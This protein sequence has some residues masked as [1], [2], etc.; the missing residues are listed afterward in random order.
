MVESNLLETAAQSMEGGSD[1]LANYKGLWL[2]GSK[3][4]HV[5]AGCDGQSAPALRAQARLDLTCC[6]RR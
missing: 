4:D 6:V 2:Y 1:A 3:K 5:F